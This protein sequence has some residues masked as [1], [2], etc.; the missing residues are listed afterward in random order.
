MLLREFKMG[1]KAAEAARKVNQELGEDTVKVR[2]AQFWFKKFRQGDESLEDDKGRGR[3]S[4]V[5]DEQLRAIVSANPS[6]STREIAK[7]LEVGH[8]TIV[9]HLNR[10]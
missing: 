9:R 8:S 4:L 2:T 7:E 3:P 1:L 6:K 5:D 10:Y